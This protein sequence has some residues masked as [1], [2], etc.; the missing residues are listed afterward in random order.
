MIYIVVIILLIFLSFHYDISGKV[1]YR[2]FWY[3]IILLVF[4]LVA[5]LRWRLG[6]D[7]PNYLGKFYHVYPTIDHYSF[8]I[9]N[10]LNS[11]FFVLLNSIVK[12]YCGRFYIVQLICAT[13]VNG[14]IFIYIK[15][16]TTC[17]FTSVLFYAIFA[18][19][20]YNMEIM[21]GSLSIV[22]CLFANDYFINKKWLKGY[23]LLIIALLFHPQT[24]VMFIM[25]FLLFLRCNKLGVLF[26]IGA[27]F[28]GQFV[29][30][31][32][33]DYLFLLDGV[34]DSKIGYK[35]QSYSDSEGFG[36]QDGGLSFYLLSVFFPIFYSVFSILYLRK[37]SKD[38]H[39]LKYE[40]FLMFFIFFLVIRMNIDI[41]YRYVEYYKVYCAL[42]FSELFV[43]VVANRH[44]FSLCMAYVRIFAFFFPFFYYT[45][46]AKF[47]GG[48]IGWRYYPY[49][50]IFEREIDKDRQLRY[51]KIGSTAYP[52]V[53][54]NE[55]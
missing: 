40:P 51:N 38:N 31:I 5:G 47:F 34:E 37:T 41:A 29:W 1:K 12:S 22:I 52:Y 26:M 55:Y 48:G 11:P 25:P 45:V 49:T 4:I 19:T 44:K 21:R 7:T 13:I 23:G 2:D 27:F 28:L 39:L 53:N 33:G 32:A 20:S 30:S 43:R 3:N 6:V 9:F 36:G 46:V 10:I 8:N 15:R 24:I 18:Y 42:F 54:V 17:I 14:L 35:I 16:H 50:S